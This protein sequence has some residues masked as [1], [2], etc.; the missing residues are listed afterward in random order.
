MFWGVC[1]LLSGCG[2]FHDSYVFKSDGS[3]LVEKD[4]KTTHF[5]HDIMDKAKSIIEQEAK[6]FDITKL[7]DYEYKGTKLFADVKSVVNF[8]PKL[9]SPDEWH[10]GIQVK[11]GF[12]Y[13]YYSIDLFMKKDK[14]NL[15]SNFAQLKVPDY[16]SKNPGMSYYEQRIQLKDSMRADF[17]INLPNEADSSNADSKTNENKTL[18]W[19]MKPWVIGD[20]TFHADAK[21]K[22][23]HQNRLIMLLVLAVILSITTI[24]LVVIDILK[25]KNSR[26]K[27]YFAGSAIA[28]FLILS[29]S[30][31]YIKHALENPPVLTTQD[32]IIADNAKDSE[33]KP[34]ADTLKK[35]D[36][37]KENSLEEIKKILNKKNVEGEVLAGSV[38]DNNGFLALVKGNV[39]YDF[40]VYSAKDDKVGRFQQTELEQEDLIPHSSWDILKYRADAYGPDKNGKLN[41]Y[42]IIFDMY[43]ENDDKNG[44]DRRLGIWHGTTHTIPIYALFDI[45]ENDKVIPGLISSAW[46]QTMPKHYQEPLKEQSNVNLVNCVLTHLD[47]LRTDILKRNINV[48]QRP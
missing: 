46:G 48:Y 9:W 24:G 42:P 19:D 16:F 22:I 28:I 13:D 26:L 1:L 30:G 29:G 43:I 12:L 44:N 27:K 3:V 39:T 25:R 41:Y 10:K 38:V 6:G 32:R 5:E 8:N 4:I 34:L 20:T 11:K 47:S 21:F 33:G 23:Y 18:T 17:T 37:T 7:N 14:N 36:D 31:I 45:D 40:V 35:I 2:D 15:R